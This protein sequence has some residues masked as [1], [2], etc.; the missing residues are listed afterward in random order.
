MRILIAPTAFKGS[1]SPAA[2]A[3]AMFAGAERF[4]KE[5][6]QTVYIDLLALADGGDGTVEALKL[7]CGGTV[8][9]LKASGALGEDRVAAWLELGD[10][11]VAELASACGIAG[12]APSELRPLDAHTRG[13]GQVLRQIVENTSI[14]K[15]VVALGGSASTDG[16]SGAL[17]ELGVKFFDRRANEVVP[18]GGGILHSISKCEL[19]QA[20]QKFLGRKVQVATDVENPLLGSNGAAAVFGPQKGASK[21]NIE[22]LEFGL[23]CFSSVLEKDAGTSAKYLIGSGAAGGTAFGLSSALGAEI[24]SGFDWLS[25]LLHLEERVRQSDLIISG[26]GRIDKSSLQGKVVGS[27]NRLCLDLKKPLWLVAGSLD[28]KLERSSI[29][30]AELLIGL[31]KKGEFAGLDQIEQAV[32]DSLNKRY[33]I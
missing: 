24:I 18:A 20:R 7:S 9:Q 31:S 10:T 11:A 33:T 15:I 25:S 32:F 22:E 12:I 16:G 29:G 30:A 5:S 2:V 3:R 6:G 4:A 8:H 21:Q 28:D 13:L 14:P 19:A 26:E 23:S 1:F 27:L 17:Y